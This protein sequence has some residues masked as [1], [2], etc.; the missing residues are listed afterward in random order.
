MHKCIDYM[1]LMCT[2]IY[3]ILLIKKF[4]TFSHD[5]NRKKLTIFPIK[6]LKKNKSLIEGVDLI[7][8]QKKKKQRRP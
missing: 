8:T 6:S 3:Q 7:H 2:N 4:T 1:Y 5:F